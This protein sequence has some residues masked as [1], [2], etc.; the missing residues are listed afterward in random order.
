MKPP[1]TL[2]LVTPLNWQHRLRYQLEQMSKC[3]SNISFGQTI[4]NADGD[5]NISCYKA[6]GTSP[7]TINTEFS[8]THTLNHVPL[9]FMIVSTDKAAHIYKSTTAWTAATKSSL[10]SIFLKSDV[11]SVAF[12]IIIL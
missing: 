2:E 8:V 1:R 5:I 6:S 3:L 10:G 11:A 7:G 9:G 12:S 4:S